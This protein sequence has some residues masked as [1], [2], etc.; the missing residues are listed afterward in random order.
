MYELFEKPLIFI[1]FVLVKFNL[2]IDNDKQHLQK[3]DQYYMSL[4]IVEIC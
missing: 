2:V 1:W 3:A 4:A